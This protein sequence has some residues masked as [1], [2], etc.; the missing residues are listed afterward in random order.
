M[1]DEETSAWNANGNDIWNP[2]DID[3]PHVNCMK[4]A[5]L[6]SSEGNL[7]SFIVHI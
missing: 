6:I 3:P 7:V 1:L 4:K 2:V 5:E